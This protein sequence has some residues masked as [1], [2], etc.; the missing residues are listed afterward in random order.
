MKIVDEIYAM[1]RNHLCGDEDDL[2]ALVMGLFLDHN[3]DDLLTMI[4][5]MSREELLQMITLYMCQLLRLKLE[6]EGTAVRGGS[7]GL[8]LRRLH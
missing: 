3:R 6:R 2:L 8:T 5:E 7:D 1:Y 4:A